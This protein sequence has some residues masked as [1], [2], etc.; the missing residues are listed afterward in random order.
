MP[1][2]PQPEVRYTDAATS[3]DTGRRGPVTRRRFQSGCFT[4]VDGRMYCMFYEDEGGRTKRVKH[5][6]GRVGEMSERAA[7]REHA[8]IMEHV[9]RKRGSVAPAYKGHS[10]ADITALWRRAIAPT[11]SPSTLRQ[12][13]S[14]LR[15]HILPSFENVA[16]HE[17]NAEALQEF[18]NTLRKTHSRKTIINVLSAVFAVL[19]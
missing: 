5:L 2:C 1:L 14:Y 19:D 6:I 9:N 10:F 13:E 3:S 12:R 11:L 17:V 7:R 16:A 15:V 4:V 18:A 8:R